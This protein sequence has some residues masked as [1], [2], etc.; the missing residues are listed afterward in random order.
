[1]CKNKIIAIKNV[2]GGFWQLL[3]HPKI[4][5]MWAEYSSGAIT[6]YYRDGRN[7][8]LLTKCTGYNSQYGTP[9]SNDGSKLFVG[10]WEKNPGLRC[11]STEQCDTIWK[12]NYGRIRQVF[13]FDDYLAVLKA[14][15][16]LL[17]IEINS[18]KIIAQIN[19]SSI[20]N[21]Y[22]LSKH[23]V[24]VE[25]INNEFCVVNTQA[26]KITK[27]YPQSVLNPNKCKSFIVNHVELVGRQIIV[28]GF[29]S[30]AKDNSS[31]CPSLIPY[32]RIIDEC[33][34]G[35]TGDNN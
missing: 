18:G 9:V 15:D 26:M 21:Q 12:I 19:S 27:E 14:Q 13:C 31:V 33:F 5:K 24:F 17:K 20:E 1:M 11:Y 22:L 25:S 6:L 16:A 35:G 8:T 3:D 7:Q 28:S 2:E 30:L 29:E 32:R 10:A 34:Q 4:T 23:L